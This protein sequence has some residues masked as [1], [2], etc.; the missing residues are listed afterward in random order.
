MPATL[1]HTSEPFAR[2][3]TLLSSVTC[4]SNV[5]PF[6]TN[7][8]MADL[9][10]LSYCVA[11]VASTSP[12]TALAALRTRTV[13]APVA[14]SISTW[15]V[16]S[17]LY[18]ADAHCSW[19]LPQ[20]ELNSNLPAAQLKVQEVAPAAEDEPE[21]HAVQDAAPALALYVLAAQGVADVAPVVG[22][23]DPAGASVQAVAPA[24]ALKEPIGQGVCA[25]APD[26]ATNE[27]GDA[28]VAAVDPV[29]DAYEPAGAMV[30]AVALVLGTKYPGAASVAAVAPAVGTYEPFGASV[31]LAD[32][33]AAAKVPATHA[34]HDAWPVAGWADPAGHE[35]HEDADMAKTLRY[36]LVASAIAFGH[37]CHD[38]PSSVPSR[39][40]FVHLAQIRKCKISFC[41]T[42][43]RLRLPR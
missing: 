9:V 35:T 4:Q 21:G 29:P 40:R 30:G 10:A 24:V 43:L 23:A 41:G 32:P 39:T 33:A 42:T 3:H 14:W 17:A 16:P 5:A 12:S 18:S 13:S 19:L 11:V 25:A 15:R 28:N 37:S 1:H 6:A 31:Q 2:I 20:L 22:T 7:E 36:E 38:G 34:S 27:P 8:A 26:D